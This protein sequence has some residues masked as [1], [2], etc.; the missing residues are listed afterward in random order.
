MAKSPGIKDKAEKAET[1]NQIKQVIETKDSPT[2]SIMKAISWRIIASTTTFIISFIIFRQVT[3]KSL[4][5]SM[6][7]ASYV[8]I[9]DV[10][11]KLIFYY[12]HERMWA[13]ITWGKYWRRRYWKRRAWKRLYRKMHL[14]QNN[15]NV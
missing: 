11:A 12:F 14:H 9:I 6:E 8:A 2:R 5:E 15:S 13:N 1:N 3:N 10:G 4:S 7:S